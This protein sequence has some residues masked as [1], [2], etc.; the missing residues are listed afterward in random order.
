MRTREE[1]SFYRNL[2][3]N[4][5]LPLF[6]L[7]F[8]RFLTENGL[9]FDFVVKLINFGRKKIF[10]VEKKIWLQKTFCTEKSF[11]STDNKKNSLCSF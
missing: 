2:F 9:F 11:W 8:G 4:K 7:N 5:F 3:L 1:R 10:C 6:C